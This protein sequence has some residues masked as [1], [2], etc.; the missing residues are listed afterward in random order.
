MSVEPMPMR[1]PAS[2]VIAIAV[3]LMFVTPV[4]AATSLR[5][6]AI[7]WDALIAFV[8]EHQFALLLGFSLMV[9]IALSLTSTQRP[10]STSPA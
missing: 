7:R 1:M 2:V 5:P 6:L 9:V 4:F 3:G 8:S 10:Q